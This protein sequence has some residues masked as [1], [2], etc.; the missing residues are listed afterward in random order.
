MTFEDTLDEAYRGFGQS[1][2]LYTTD[3]R[4]LYYGRPDVY[5]TFTNDGEI[6]TENTAQEMD[7]PDSIICYDIRDVI[8]KKVTSSAFYANVFRIKKSG[9]EFIDD[10]RRYKKDELLADVAILRAIKV[11]DPIDFDAMWKKINRDTTIRHDFVKLWLLTEFIAKQRNSRDFGE[12]WQSLLL[13]LGYIGFSDPSKTGVLVGERE[14][15]TIYLDY[16]SR[17][18]FDILPIQKHREDPR[19]RVRDK[20]ERKMKR[21]QYTTK[22]NRIAKR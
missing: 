7:R 21:M 14:P 3:L 18:E 6:S 2:H 1:S 9:G 12:V 16:E 4:T 11:I 20:I 15:V 5:L 13:R 17:K 22:R 8:G 19:Q 10:I